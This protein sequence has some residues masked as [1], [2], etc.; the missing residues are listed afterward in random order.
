[1]NYRHILLGADFSEHGGRVAQRALDLAHRHQAELSV[2]HVVENLQYMDAAYGPIVPFEVDLTGQLVEA[3]R[4][5][6]DKLAEGLSIPPERRW[7]EIGSPKLEITRLAE[8][9]GVDLIVVG[10]HGRHGLA[11]LLGSTASGVL[12]HAECDVLAVRLRA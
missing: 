4:R 9:R 6:L 3:A 7:V 5:R 12:H 1:M 10:S 2:V 8:E 11:L